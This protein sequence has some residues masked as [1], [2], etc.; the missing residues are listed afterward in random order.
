MPI[1]LSKAFL[2]NI[3]YSNKMEVSATCVPVNESGEG[4]MVSKGN[5]VQL[6]KA[7]RSSQAVH[8]SPVLVT[9]TRTIGVVVVSQAVQVLYQTTTEAYLYHDTQCSN[10]EVDSLAGVPAHPYPGI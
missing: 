5:K 10:N 2:Q 1:S 7:T 9:P 4:M 8:G 6:G 3:L